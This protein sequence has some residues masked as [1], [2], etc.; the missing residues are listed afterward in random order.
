MDYVFFSP[1][2]KYDNVFLC[3]SLSL[4][5]LEFAEFLG[6]VDLHIPLDLDFFIYYSFKYSFCFFLCLLLGLL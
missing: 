4:P 2:D 1:L 3:G 5:F 6:Y